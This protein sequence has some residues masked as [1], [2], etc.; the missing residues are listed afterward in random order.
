KFHYHRSDII[1]D[2][3]TRIM[4][5]IPNNMWRG[6]SSLSRRQGH[7]TSLVFGSPPLS[8]LMYSNTTAESELMRGLQIATATPTL[9]FF[10]TLTFSQQSGIFQRL[11]RLR[12]P[13]L[14]HRS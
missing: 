1:V 6:I 12:Y 13:S 7:M 10:D 4:G 14:K 3:L 9:I 8:P 2:Q 5:E 11:R